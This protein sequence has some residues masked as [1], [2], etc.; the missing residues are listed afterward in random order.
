M[1]PKTHLTKLTERREV[2]DRTLAISVQKP[3]GFNFT[4]GQFAELSVISPEDDA[5]SE[6]EQ[7]AFSIASSPEE[8]ELMFATRIRGGAFK[9]ALLNKALGSEIRLEGPYGNFILHD[10][11]TRAAVFLAGGIGITP[12]RSILLHAAKANLPNQLVLF[13]SNRKPED[14]AFLDELRELESL[15]HNYRFI[16]VM[17]QS[18]KSKLE[19]V[20]ETGHIDYK[21]ISKYLD[22]VVAPIY[23][24]VGSPAFVQALRE[25]LRS[26]GV[27]NDD[28]RSEDFVG[29]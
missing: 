6:P 14:A 24:V 21:M 28:I 26:A 13:Y 23:Y 18:Q 25:M 29:Y 9:Q 20:G 10:D 17:T 27:K 19:W 16:P 12:V 5:A 8:T 3:A 7:L 1:Q 11:A 2:A 22:A 4:A 15:N